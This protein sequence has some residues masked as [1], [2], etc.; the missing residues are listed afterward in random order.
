LLSPKQASQ[1][2]LK[3]IAKS[4]FLAFVSGSLVSIFPGLGPAQAA[5]LVSVKRFVLRDYMTI[6]GGINTVSMLFAL[7]TTFTIGKARNGSIVVVQKLV[8]LDFLM[9][10][11]F[12]AVSI[13]SALAAFFLVLKAAKLMSVFL[14]KINYQKVCFGVII[15]VFSLS[16][17][18]AGVKGVLLLSAAA[19]IGLVPSITKVHRSHLMGCLLLP[20]IVYFL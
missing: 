16:F 10:V 20:V 12:A 9:L 19:A 15:F 6:I 14:M 2:F 18:F 4:S 8:E 7:V 13:A 11:F 3:A 5:A 1:E 17:Y